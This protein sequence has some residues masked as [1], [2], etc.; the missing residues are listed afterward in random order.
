M[1]P[2]KAGGFSA[3]PS[4]ADPRTVQQR[5]GTDPRTG[6]CSQNQRCNC[7]GVRFVLC[8]G[9]LRWFLF[10]WCFSFSGALLPARSGPEVVKQFEEQVGADPI[11]EL[12]SGTPWDAMADMVWVYFITDTILQRLGF[13]LPRLRLLCRLSHGLFR[14]C[15]R[16][17]CSCRCCE[18]GQPNLRVGFTPIEKS[19][20]IVNAP[21]FRY[22]VVFVVGQNAEA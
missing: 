3:L 17:R 5:K 22:I 21:Q 14:P 2:Q 18:T 16:P 13:V 12:S 10:L 15:H 8:S 20:K 1:T 9:W 11:T 19:K 6:R 4:G 7:P